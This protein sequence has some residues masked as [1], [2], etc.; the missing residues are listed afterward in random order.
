MWLW[1][2]MIASMPGTFAARFV[3]TFLS[4]STLFG[5]VGEADVG[6]RDDRVIPAVQHRD[7]I[8]APFAI[9]LVKVRPGM[10]LGSS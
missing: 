8:L 3:S 2:P 4:T 5:F 9:G 10:L 1:L 7:Q 6:Q